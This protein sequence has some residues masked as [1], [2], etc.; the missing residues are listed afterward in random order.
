MVIYDKETRKLMSLL[1]I[2]NFPHFKEKSFLK[3]LVTITSF[4]QNS[5]KE[6]NYDSQ[7]IILIMHY[8][9]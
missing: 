5:L 8:I 9:F 6:G 2:N 4:D 7:I 1:L 3:L